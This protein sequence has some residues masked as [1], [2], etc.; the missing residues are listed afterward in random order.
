M[1]KAKNL[2]IYEPIDILRRDRL[3]I[4]DSELAL[5]EERM[6]YNRDRILR[7][8][9]GWRGEV[10][11]HTNQYVGFGS[12][13][14]INLT[15][16]PKVF[17]KARERGMFD[18]QDE[19]VAFIRLIDISLQLELKESYAVL[20]ERG[21][22]ERSIY[23][24]LMYLY[25]L[26]LYRE[27]QNGIY[28][29]YIGE[30]DDEPFLRGKLLISRQIR[31]LPHQLTTFIQE[32]YTLS[33]DNELN[34]ILRFATTLCEQLSSHRDT[35]T[36]AKLISHIL[37]EV[38][39]HGDT[40]VLMT[41]KELVFNR[42]NERFRR[43]YNLAKLILNKVE[44]GRGREVYGFFIKMNDLFEQFIY[45]LLKRELR[46]YEVV[47]GRSIG[48]LLLDLSTEGGS[49]VF[50]QIPD[51]IVSKDGK[52]Q[53]IVD[54]KYKELKESRD[55]DEKEG[56]DKVPIDVNDV[57]QLYVYSRLASMKNASIKD[58]D[59]D[60]YTPN[61]VLV[62]PYLE[63]GFNKIF[64]DSSK[65]EFEF[66]VDGRVGNKLI[67]TRYDFK[68]L[69]RDRVVDRELLSIIRSSMPE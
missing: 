38:T 58:R 44:V 16:L 21:V 9:F 39:T 35:V 37:S 62:Y 60:V 23:E 69:T 27:L 36:Y 51:I 45:Q 20:R 40:R 7:V 55:Y 14:G 19:V 48:R 15:I 24:I 57:R 47:H 30:V 34:R 25:T 46:G 63:R 52:I 12:V 29:R 64:D 33:M 13:D 53:L 8:H 56:Y 61:T 1:R 43:P 65:F 59:E 67:V 3:E 17:K 32:R 49:R 10:S 42:L 41:K 22:A 54:V 50:A 4:T 31:K 2:V 5:I 68:N 11:I 6:V 28:R 18:I 66:I 26:M